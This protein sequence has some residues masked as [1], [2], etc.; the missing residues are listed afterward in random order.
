MEF[1]STSLKP[2]VA[3]KKP[4]TQGK[5]VPV[6]KKA[7]PYNPVGARKPTASTPTPTQPNANMIGANAQETAMRNR[8]PVSTE[9]NVSYESDPVLARI[10]AIGGQDVG[11]ARTEAEALRKKAIL[12]SGL[13]DVGREIGVDDATLQAAAANPFSTSATIQ[14]T[15]QERGR[16]LDESLNQQ[17]LFYS[18]HRANELSELGRNTAEAQSNLGS[19]IRDLLGGINQGVTSA[20][21][22]AARAEQEALEQVAEQARQDALQQ[23]YLDALAGGGD[24]A[25]ELGMAPA[26]LTDVGGYAQSV[27]EPQQFISNETAQMAGVDP[28]YYDPYEEELAMLLAQNAIPGAGNRYI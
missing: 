6:M 18:G 3:K 27:Y 23:A 25:S 17:N 10:R 5:V 26:P 15:A 22:A 14:R 12:D 19:S 9:L 2:S 16:A 8:A 13:T 20:E 7:N 11:N 21:T 1:L 4:K 28:Y 24:L